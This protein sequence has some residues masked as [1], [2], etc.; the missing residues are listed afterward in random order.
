MLLFNSPNRLEFKIENEFDLHSKVVE[1]IRRFY[2]NALLVANL[3]ELQDTK[4]KRINSYKK[5]YQKSLIL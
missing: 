3:G 1:Y 4:S 2:P 5:G